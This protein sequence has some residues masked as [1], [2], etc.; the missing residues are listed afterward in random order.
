MLFLQYEFHNILNCAI[1]RRA[2]FAQN[3]GGDV[4]ALGEFAQG[5][6]RDPGFALQ[7]DFL[8]ILIDEQ[9]PKSFYN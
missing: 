5:I 9:F 6:V 4:L 3:F 8:H 2:D 1:Q 7:I